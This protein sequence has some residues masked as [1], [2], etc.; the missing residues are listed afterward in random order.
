MI[1][2]H[3]L[4]QHHL[5]AIDNFHAAGVLAADT[6]QGLSTLSLRHLQSQ[7]SASREQARE[8]VLGRAQTMDLEA[9]SAVIR[10]SME[11]LANSYARWVE[12]VEAQLRLLRLGA[13]ESFEDLRRWTP[14]G[15]EVTVTA[16]ELAI[17]AA[18]SSAELIA[19]ASVAASRMLEEQP[20]SRPARA[21]QRRR[22]AAADAS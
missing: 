12:L 13:H 1:A 22:G 18:E 17:D 21:S 14:R 10:E 5:D 9:S 20:T 7:V 3:L 8:I 11:L 19:E 15:T 4:R 16:A 2:R 6:L